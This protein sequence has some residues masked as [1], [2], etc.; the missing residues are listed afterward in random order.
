MERRQAAHHPRRLGPQELRRI[1]VLLLGHEARSR[2]EGVGDLAEPELLAGPQHQ[3][4]AELRQVGG[5]GRGRREQVEHVVAVGH[6]VQR[7]LPHAREAELVGEEVA[8]G[9]EVGAGQGA[10]P[11]RQLARRLEGEGEAKP[12]AAQAPEVRQKVMGQVHRLGSLQVGVGRYGPVQVSLGLLQQ[13]L[14]EIAGEPARRERTLTDVQRHVRG[15][16]VVARAGGVQPPAGLAD[17][18]RQAALDGHVHILVVL[19]DLEAPLLDL[20]LHLG[21]AALDGLQVLVADDSLPGQHP[22]VGDRSPDVLRRQAEVEP[23][24]RVQGLEQGILRV[25]QPGHH[26]EAK[27][28]GGVL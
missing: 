12:V 20:L 11:Q 4:G 5:A 9:L 17:Q 26:G 16:L 1:G 22:G 24:R 3:L 28:L 21:Q 7:V 27:G 10:R 23:H 13:R 6:R 8:V 25:G 15:H 18:L 14:H 2:R 19:V